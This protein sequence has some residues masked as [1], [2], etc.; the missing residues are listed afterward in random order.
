MIRCWLLLSRYLSMAC[1]LVMLSSPSAVA[2]SAVAEQP[3]FSET[4]DALLT[5]LDVP[6]TRHFDSMVNA[7]QIWRRSPQ[8]ER[9][10]LPDLNIDQT[11]HNEAFTLLQRLDLVTKITP[12][13]TSYDYALWL[14]ATVP[15]MQAR[16]EHLVR[17]W[18]S[19]TG[20]NKI[21]ALVGLRP[22][23]PSIDQIEPL[24]TQLA[25]KNRV[26]ESRPIT[27][28]EG[29]EMIYLLTQMPDA[30]RHTAIEYI[31]TPRRWEKDHWQRP[32]TRDTVATWLQTH[33][34]PGSVLVISEQPNAHYQMEVVRQTLPKT[35][36][37]D[38]AAAKAL[39]DTR[40]ALILDALALW[41]HNLPKQ[42]DF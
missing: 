9:W 18:E 42:P 24:T 8:Q 17:L 31:S 22:I 21:I 34:K 19:G 26:R 25:G 35:F 41:L 23:M 13:R 37:V 27:E 39:P 4:L 1:V 11:T 15:T 7:S 12:Q 6:H 3:N 33:P 14:G 10:Q 5:I 16:L 30:M 28:L 2:G 32:N 20:F 36:S 29:A 38:L 40:L